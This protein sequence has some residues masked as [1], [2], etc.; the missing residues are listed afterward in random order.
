MGTSTQVRWTE[1]CCSRGEAYLL[2]IPSH[3]LLKLCENARW[4]SREGAC[5][6]RGLKFL[7]DG[8][9]VQRALLSRC[10]GLNRGPEVKTRDAAGKKRALNVD[11]EIRTGVYRTSCK[12]HGD[13]KGRRS[14]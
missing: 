13:D 3:R 5:W 4:R 11:T 1:C 7:D 10:G 6:G 8:V 14:G 12:P 2:S 9:P